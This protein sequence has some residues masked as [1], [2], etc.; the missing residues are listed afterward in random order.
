ML[1]ALPASAPPLAFRVFRRNTHS[2]LFADAHELFLGVCQQNNFLV[3]SI[4]AGF[5]NSK[6]LAPRGPMCHLF[7]RA[8]WAIV[9]EQPALFEKYVEVNGSSSC[10]GKAGPIVG[11]ILRCRK[12]C[13]RT[14]KVSLINIQTERDHYYFLSRL[15]CSIIIRQDIHCSNR[16]GSGVL[17]HRNQQTVLKGRRPRVKDIFPP[18]LRQ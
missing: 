8:R 7:W 18:A 16:N 6:R 3:L 2:D 10:T 12:G 4:G 1:V 13:R 9:L 17:V 5:V 15:S 11:T 14:W